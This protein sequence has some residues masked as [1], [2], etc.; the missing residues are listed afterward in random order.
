MGLI[1]IKLTAFYNMLI[2]FLPL[3]DMTTLRGEAKPFFNRLRNWVTR[4]MHLNKHLNRYESGN[5]H[6]LVIGNILIN[7]GE[8]KSL[9]HE[10]LSE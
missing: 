7:L 10:Q 6:G 5:L 3:S 1:Y 4:R 9:V 2:E 8:T